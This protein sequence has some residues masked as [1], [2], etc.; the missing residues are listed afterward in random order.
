MIV[1]YSRSCGRLNFSLF[2]LY[3]SIFLTCVFVPCVW[4]WYVMQTASKN[5]IELTYKICDVSLSLSPK[6]LEQFF[7]FICFTTINLL[8]VWFRCVSNTTCIFDALPILRAREIGKL[9]L[10]ILLKSIGIII[11]TFN[12]NWCSRTKCFL[13]FHW[14]YLVM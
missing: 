10:K 5:R 11:K 7:I 3:F 4:V 8:L 6:C 1:L 13:S 2:Y 12:D 9:M 14:A